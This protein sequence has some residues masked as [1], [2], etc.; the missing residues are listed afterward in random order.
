M[1]TA[2][3]ERRHLPAVAMGGFSLAILLAALAPDYAGHFPARLLLAL[4]VAGSVRRWLDTADSGHAAAL[5]GPERLGRI[6]P[7]HAR[8]S[9]SLN[10]SAI[11]LGSATSVAIGAVVVANGARGLGWGN[12]APLP[13]VE[14]GSSVSGRV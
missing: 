3:W 14:S 8:I 2:G 6:A 9:L 10:S 12:L 5:G 1:L 11:Y 7:E 13:A 4:S